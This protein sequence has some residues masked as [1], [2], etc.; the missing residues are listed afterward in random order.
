[1]SFLSILNDIPFILKNRNKSK[2]AIP[3]LKN[4]SERGEISAVTN[5]AATGVNPAENVK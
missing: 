4:A 3:N 1:M 2:V 5:L